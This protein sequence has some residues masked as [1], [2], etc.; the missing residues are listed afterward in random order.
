MLVEYRISVAVQ[1]GTPNELAESL[2]STAQ[3]A[4]SIIGYKVVLQ[5]EVLKFQPSKSGPALHHALRSFGS[6]L[7]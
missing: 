7:A 1:T 6:L 4:S 2:A 5:Q 3:S